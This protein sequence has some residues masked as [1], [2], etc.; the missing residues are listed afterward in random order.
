M[1][2]SQKDSQEVHARLKDLGSIHPSCFNGLWTFRPFFWPSPGLSVHSSH[3][4]MP[5]LVCRDLRAIIRLLLNREIT[6]IKGKGNFRAPIVSSIGLVWPCQPSPPHARLG[7]N[8]ETPKNKP[9]LAPKVPQ[10]RIRCTK[11]KRGAI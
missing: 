7:S 6:R 5:E 8:L 3:L 9:V 11:T 4:L 1:G 10:K 2:K